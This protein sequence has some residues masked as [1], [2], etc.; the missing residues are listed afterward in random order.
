MSF[1]KQLAIV[2]AGLLLL[3]VIPA[4]MYG[5]ITGEKGMPGW[6]SGLR[7]VLLLLWLIGGVIY[8]AVGTA[9]RHSRERE[10]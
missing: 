9:I 6:L 5:L 3:V 1:M 10:S 4:F 2:A 7:L 8:I